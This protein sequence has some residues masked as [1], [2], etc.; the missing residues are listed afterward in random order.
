L[1]LV[2]DK[3]L[4]ELKSDSPNLVNDVNKTDTSSSLVNLNKSNDLNISN[5]DNKSNHNEFN[6]SNDEYTFD[7]NLDDINQISINNSF[8]D[9]KRFGHTTTLSNIIIV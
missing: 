7:D 5:D 9:I 3:N 4:M 2:V 8:S 1:N 6:K